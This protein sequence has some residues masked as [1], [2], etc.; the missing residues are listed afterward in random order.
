MERK[1]KNL[2]PFHDNSVLEV[3]NL[4]E[5]YNIRDIFDYMDT[6]I[7]V[8]TPYNHGEDFI[9]VDFNK[10]GE[11]I[12]NRKKEDI[13]GEKLTIAF[14][15]AAKYGLL[16]V[17]RSVYQTGT[18]QHVIISM[19]KNGK[20][21]AFREN[22]VYKIQSGE[23][24]SMFRD[25][26]RQ[27][28][29]LE[30]L[31]EKKQTLQEE[32]TYKIDQINELRSELAES[33]ALYRSLVE[34]SPEAICVAKDGYFTY[35]NPA[36]VKLY[37]AKSANELLGKKI[38]SFNIPEERKLSVQRLNLLS[39][40]SSIPPRKM[41]IKRL[42]GKII[43]IISR[44][45]PINYKKQKAILIMIHDIT[46]VVENHLKLK[47]SKYILQ[48]YN[49]CKNLEQFLNKVAEFITETTPWERAGI[50]INYNGNNLD[51]QQGFPVKEWEKIVQ[52]QQILPKEGKKNHSMSVLVSDTKSIL[53]KIILQS[54]TKKTISESDIKIL[55]SIGNSIAEATKKYV[56]QKNLIE[57]NELIEKIFSTSNVLIAYLDKDLNFIRV[58]K[59]YAESEQK[60]PEYYIGKNHFE[61][62]PYKENKKIFR[63]ILKTGKPY[64]AYNKPF[65]YKYN[66]ERGI[67]YWNWIAQCVKDEKGMAAG[68]L[69]FFVNVT[70]R[71]LMEEKLIESYK[72]L[73]VINRQL[74][75][76]LDLN[77]E[78]GGKQTN[79][80]IDYVI[81]SATDI[82]GAKIV[83]LYTYRRKRNCFDLLGSSRISY[84]FDRQC[85]KITSSPNLKKIVRDKKRIQ[86]IF[87]NEIGK[88]FKIGE[89]IKYLIFLPLVTE[90][91]LRGIIILGFSEKESISTQEMD[92]Y[93]AFATQAAFIMKNLK[94][95]DSKPHKE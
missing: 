70:E 26:S 21:Y 61:L 74:S 34:T 46:N 49:S 37:A 60:Q 13:I 86:V 62:F 27:L 22:F 30:K 72:H 41:R 31:R 16:N 84:P 10:A 75:I 20:K 90:K 66:P 51:A 17:F 42:D 7:A 3:V 58:N 12:D 50:I 69:I 47:N 9:I 8:Y 95:F 71:H 36:A 65:E 73:G 82:S 1:H 93:E 81:N 76:L 92:F 78:S 23:I 2:S 80:I 79:T 94:V 83:N 56:T 39:K 77:K 5:N 25:V 11:K 38:I 64:Y 87:N 24:I 55:H 68:L 28:K 19:I 15:N 48:L 32:I 63:Q 4:P 67:T 57:N 54:D 33:E 52:W 29:N 91:H 18:S 53:G 43:Y 6:G 85:I 45:K 44:V 14:P 40:G 35:G 89:K 88:K 59:G